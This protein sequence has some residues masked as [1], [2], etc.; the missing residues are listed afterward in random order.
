[1]T[2]LDTNIVAVSLPSIARDLHGEFTDVEWVVSAYILPFAA[3]LMPAGALA[4]RHGRRRMLYLGLSLFTLA[5]LLCGLAPNLLVLNLARALQPVGGALQLTASLAVIAHGFEPQHR[6]RVYAIWATVMG[7][8]P[9]LGAIVGGLITSYLGWRWAFYINLPIGLGLMAL[10]LTSVD[11]S[12]DPKAARLDVPGI[13]LFGA[14]L[15]SIV[16]ALIEANRIGWGSAATL[17]KLAIGVALLVA[18]VFAERLHPRPMI[19]LVLFK[20]SSVVGAATSMLGYAAAAMLMMTILPIYLQDAF[21]QSAAQAGLAMVPFALPLFAGPAIGAKLAAQLSSRAMLT[22]GLA[23]VAA[24]DAILAAVVFAGLGYWAVVVGMAIVGFATG[25]LNSETT[26]AQVIAV[27]PERAGMAAGIAATTRFIG[28]TVGLAGLGAILTAAAESSLR[29]LGT[30]A[31]PLDSV[32]WHALNLRIVGGDAGG[33]LSDLP[34]AIRTALHQAVSAG[35]TTGF[36]A[37]FAAA[38]VIAA[39]SSVLAWRLVREPGAVATPQREDALLAA[40]A[41]VTAAD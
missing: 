24:G 33:A 21:G 13:L 7:I 18:F 25:V 17:A 12:R 38:A 39:V 23:T 34:P 20:D 26:K 28:I 5:S 16:W 14:G 37:T 1:M 30:Q 36:A 8:S 9:S 29:R 10:G 35:V 3:L 31:V 15:F 6:A 32:D 40:Q 41:E 22:L 4:D 2:M 19:D 27:P 11:E